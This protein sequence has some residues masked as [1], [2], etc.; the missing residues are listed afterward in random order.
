MQMLVDPLTHRGDHLT[1]GVV[2]DG[3]VVVRPWYGALDMLNC[4]Q[5]V[6][7]TQLSETRLRSERRG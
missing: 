5:S 1:W 4:L 2:R 3:A 6:C 7:L